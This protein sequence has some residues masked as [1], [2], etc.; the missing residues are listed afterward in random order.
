MNHNQIDAG[1]LH[2]MLTNG[3]RNL[4]LYE[5]QVN[6]L[7]VFPVPDGDTG[8]NMV[9][10]LSGGLSVDA[11][12][13]GDVS[14]MMKQYS[15]A[16][17]LS[18]RGNSGVILSQYIRGWANA[19]AGK[20]TLCI[21]DVKEMLR[22]GVA[23]AYGAVPNPVEGTM[24]TVLRESCEALQEAEEFTE[25]AAFFSFLIEKMKVS[26]QH[27]P[28]LLPVLKDAGV[29]DSG[30][31]GMIYFI[32]GIW[33]YVN[34]EIIEADSKR[35]SSVV[36]SHG[37]G[38]GPDSILEY[39]YCT[40]FVLQL[41]N[42]KTNISA[43]SIT[44]VIEFLETV[45]DSIVAV[46]DDDIV[47]VH[48][49][50]FEPEKVLAFGRN[51]GEFV[52][53]KIENMSVQHHETSQGKAKGTKKQ[54]YAVVAVAMGEGIKN[55]FAEIGANR[56]VEGGQTQNPSTQ[57]FLDVFA[58]LNA[59]HIV[60]L[61]NNSNI[62]ATAKLAAELFDACD[63]RVVE[64]TSIAE[65]YSALSMM[66]TWAKDVDAF[67]SDMSMSL[68]SVIS[69]S[70]TTAVHDATLNGVAIKEGKYMG[71]ADGKVLCTADDKNEAALSMLKNIPDM[72]EKAVVTI[73]YGED[74]TEE[75]IDELTNSI[76][77]TYPDIECGAV[78]GGQKLYDYYMAIE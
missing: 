49:H 43:F 70:I 31:M 1:F 34:G 27:T 62:C 36:L 32:E 59:E 77:E 5:E 8:T 75:E 67:V 39:G 6:D 17:L 55:Y 52:T 7:N 25:L 22:Q 4:A 33:A 61:P 15:K 53:V 69:G 37:S 2:G 60:V 38:F 3:Y 45:G 12:A 57:D 65:G 19:V 20:A 58:S 16:V 44:P 28:E 14:A 23:S 56:I 13:C 42:A 47:K 29:V 63:V 40:E 41:M 24:L 21:A 50:T 66:N 18:A 72:E 64:T 78:S 11:E 30:G 35:E 48:V 68:G 46:C 26:I 76:A 71:M 54:K 73:F 51:Y 9:K 74:V 10:T